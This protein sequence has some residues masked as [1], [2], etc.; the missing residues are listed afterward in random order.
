[1]RHKFKVLAASAAVA[2]AGL[3]A[4][5]A[6]VALAAPITVANG[7][8]ETCTKMA[9]GDGGDASGNGDSWNTLPADGVWVNTVKPYSVYGKATTLAADVH[10]MNAADGKYV[11]NT[12]AAV[13]TGTISQV[14]TTYTVVAGDV[15]TLEFD[16]A[17]G[18]KGD[19]PGTGTLLAEIMVG[20][21]TIATDNN[22]AT[23]VAAGD[24]DHKTLTGTATTTGA[25]K[26][27]FGN[28]NVAST[29]WLDNVTMS[30]SPAVPEPAS[31]GLLSLAGLA[32]M[33]RRK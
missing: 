8:F 7:S 17:K 20:S 12:G 28:G 14:L 29:P 1:M 6:S 15:F 30:V 10:F 23:T 9:V 4:S 25:L 2:V 22:F 3:V 11:L 32:L 5:S 13:G 33:R 24:W 16:V 26:I 19:S 21:N 31:L 27:V 18:L